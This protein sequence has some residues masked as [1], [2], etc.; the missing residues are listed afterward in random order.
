MQKTIL[1]ALFN[2]ILTLATKE[3]FN[4]MA[5]MLLDVAEEWAEGDPTTKEDDK[6]VVLA[7][8]L[9]ARNILDIPDNDEDTD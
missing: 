1:M 5:D 7:L 4:K 9:K 2:M 3:N 8:C 6:T